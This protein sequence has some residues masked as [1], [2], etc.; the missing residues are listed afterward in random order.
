MAR[1][2]FGILDAE[3]GG[4]SLFTRP[5]R[6]LARRLNSGVSQQKK[7]ARMPTGLYKANVV[8]ASA[9]ALVSIFVCLNF[10]LCLPHPVGHL[11]PAASFVTAA[12]WSLHCWQL[13]IARGF[14]VKAAF[15]TTLC[16]LAFSLIAGIVWWLHYRQELSESCKALAWLQRAAV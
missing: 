11:A 14:T 7:V 1:G 12:N 4:K 5:S 15:R 9:Y 3:R 13:G 10:K 8:A 16:P 2:F 6:P